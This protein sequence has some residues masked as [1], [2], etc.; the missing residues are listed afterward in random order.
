MSTS[1]IGGKN[2]LMD[3]IIIVECTE[4]M[5]FYRNKK[6]KIYAASEKSELC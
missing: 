5:I 1:Q 4:G 2:L 6:S 3:H